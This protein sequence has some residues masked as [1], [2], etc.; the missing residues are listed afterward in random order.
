M[1]SRPVSTERPEEAIPAYRQ[2]L[3]LDPDFADAHYNVAL[4]FEARGRRSEAITHFRA[5]RK[6]YGGRGTHA[7]AD[8]ENPLQ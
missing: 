3:A 6:L 2:A 8:L 1:C 4:L 7:S 5:A